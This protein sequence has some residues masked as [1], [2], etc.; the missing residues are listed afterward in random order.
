MTNS[1]D[2]LRTGLPLVYQLTFE[3]LPVAT[4]CAVCPELH[5]CGGGSA[6]NRYSRARGFDN[7]SFW[8]K[9]LLKT[10]GHVRSAIAAATT[11]Q[12]M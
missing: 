11:H 4:T 7:P 6:T 8:C 12:T 1:F 10:I 3:Q 2:D 5:T 9:D